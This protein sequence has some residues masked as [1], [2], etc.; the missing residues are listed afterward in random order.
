MLEAVGDDRITKMARNLGRAADS[1]DVSAA[2]FL[3]H[4]VVGK[5]AEP[6]CDSDAVN[7][8]GQEIER[9]VTDAVHR[10][11]LNRLMVFIRASR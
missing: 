5:P 9:K 8:H 7:L 6:P 10:A 1:G 2:T 11:D 3:L 4:D